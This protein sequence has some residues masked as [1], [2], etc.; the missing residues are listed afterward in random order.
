MLRELHIKNLAIIDDLSI[1]FDKGLNVLT[2]ETGAGK[3]IIINA[4]SLTIGE[5]ASSDLIRTGEKEAVIEALFDISHN[6]LDRSTLQ[7]FN[8]M[9]ISIDE[10]VILKRIV[11]SH[12]RGRAYINNSLATIQNLSG[13]SMTLIDIHGQYE[14]QSLLSAD[15]QL[16]MLDA[17][18][19]LFD[20]RQEIRALYERLA[21]LKRQLSTLTEK[22][23]ER[24]QRI[25]LLRYQINEING[26]NLRAGEE[27]E[28]LEEEKVLS[29]ALRLTELA[30]QAYDSLYLSDSSCITRLKDL[31]SNLKEIADIDSTAIDTLKSLEDAM[32]LLEEAS[33]FLRDYKEGLDLS[34]Q[35]L[36]AVQERLHL[37]GGLKRKY[38]DSI[39]EILKYK[40][41]AEAELNGLEHSEERLEGLE[42]EIE[43]LKNVFTERAQRLSKKRKEAAKRLE[44]QVMKE[45]SMLSMAESRFSIHIR[46]EE[47]DDTTDGLRT[48]PSGIDHIEF[49]ISP[50]KGEELKPLSKIASGGELSRIML[51]LK[52]IL[53]RGDSIPVIVFDEIDAGIGGM[54]AESVGRKLKELSRTHQVICITHLPQ[55]ASY[56]DCHLRITKVTK[57][58]RTSVQVE[59]IDKEE[60]V[61]EIARMLSGDISDVSLKHAREMIKKHNN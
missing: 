53:T 4:L 44:H 9:G 39:E 18:G 2:G 57:G 51:A 13:L 32:P 27:E 49:L 46:H 15:T 58:K 19:G 7:S 20:E 5:R 30:S 12:S 16:R 54:A 48:T 1:E 10:G 25:D 14:H 52:G 26:A 21:D 3:S 29:N 43:R 45:L 50:N 31:I 61:A 55:I 11:S 22:G 28:L 60:R 34:P 35:R 24:A 6:S 42:T 36:D 38:G 8:D 59:R 17:Y 56:A 47:G 33:Y 40:E 41:G 23:K 37:I